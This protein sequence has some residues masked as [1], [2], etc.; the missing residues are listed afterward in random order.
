V[1]STQVERLMVEN[2]W[3]Y[4]VVAVVLISAGLMFWHLRRG[5]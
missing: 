1:N 4:F 3:V 5:D 2:T